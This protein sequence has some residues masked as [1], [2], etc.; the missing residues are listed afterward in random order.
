MAV[1]KTDVSE[2]RNVSI[3]RVKSDNELGTLAVISTLIR[4]FL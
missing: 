2:E 4:N 1:V 3:N